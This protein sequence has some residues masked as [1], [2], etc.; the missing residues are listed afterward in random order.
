MA[1]EPK[2]SEEREVV[3][4]ACG[5]EPPLIFYVDFSDYSKI[6]LRR[7]DWDQVF[8]PIFKEKEVISAKL[9]ELE[10][11]RNAL[12]HFRKL[13]EAPRSSKAQT[14]FKRRNCMHY[15]LVDQIVKRAPSESSR[16]AGP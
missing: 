7:D 16:Q 4:L 3:S 5:K 9:R 6:I 12:A 2:S 15:E 14:I 13:I 8:A 10:P 1:Q 11:V